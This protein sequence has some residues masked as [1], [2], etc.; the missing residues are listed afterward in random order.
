MARGIRSWNGL[1]KNCSS[2]T[3]EQ[4]KALL[5]RNSLSL[6]RQTE[7]LG[8][9]RSSLYYQNK[10]SEQDIVLT[11]AIDEIY[12]QRPFYGSRR[13]RKE[14][15]RKYG[16]SPCREHVQRLMR[17]MGLQAIYPKKKLS[18]PDK[19]HKVFPYLLKSLEITSP[20]QVWA[21]DITYVRLTR[22]WAYLIAVMDWFSR[23]VVSWKLSET[24]ELQ[25]CLDAL[26]E[27]LNKNTPDIFNTDQGAQFT[28]PQ[29]T[30]ILTNKKIQVS[31]DSKG[32]YTDNIFVERLWRT[33]KY[34]DIYLKH[35]ESVEE[36]Q[37]G[38]EGYFDFYNNERFHS[39][40]NDRT[41][42]EVYFQKQ[43]QPLVLKTHTLHLLNS[44]SVS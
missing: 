38:L 8:M 19:E 16:L 3:H 13:V 1:K 11:R 7:L 21:A 9:S 27:A 29:F 32:R 10:T 40:L 6:K 36:A 34:E 23:Y 33:V 30:E 25:F 4:K 31:M 2:L 24:L 18:L 35:Y 5:E 41:P 26:N 20:N 39:S 14:L 44:N 42:A 28:S 15:K 17:L 43:S 22:G 37:K 12:T